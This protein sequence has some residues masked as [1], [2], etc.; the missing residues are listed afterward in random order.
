MNNLCSEMP[1]TLI[2][3]IHGKYK[4]WW[5]VPL[6]SM[7]IQEVLLVKTTVRVMLLKHSK[8]QHGRGGKLA[9]K[10]V[11]IHKMA[12]GFYC[13]RGS[14]R[15]LRGTLPVSKCVSWTRIP[16]ENVSFCKDKTI[17]SDTNCTLLHVL[18]SAMYVI[19][20]FT[21]MSEIALR[22]YN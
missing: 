6:F 8:R 17:L 10:T 18:F 5:K 16:N 13:W 4:I 19:F 1:S 7:R 21:C 22:F 2:M 14:K 9:F 12:W 11:L 20:I 3:T 15:H